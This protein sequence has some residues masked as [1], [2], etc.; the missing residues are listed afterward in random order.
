MGAD[1]NPVVKRRGRDVG[2]MVFVRLELTF[3][4]SIVVSRS[5]ELFKAIAW[6]TG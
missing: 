1:A 2:L 6:A 3:I 4:S 5:R